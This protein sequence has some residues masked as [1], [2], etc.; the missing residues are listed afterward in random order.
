VGSFERGIIQSLARSDKWSLGGAGP[1]LFAP[2]FPAALSRPGFWDPAQYYRH[3]IGP[4]FTLDLLDLAGDPIELSVMKRRWNPAYVITEYQSPGGLKLSERKVVLPSGALVS[5]VRFECDR[6]LDVVLAAWTVQPDEGWAYVMS[7]CVAIP[8]RLSAPAGA[9]D[10]VWLALTMGPGVPQP[11]IVPSES[12]MQVPNWRHCALWE[13]R[14]TTD[15]APAQGGGFWHAGL[16]LGLSVSARGPVIANVAMSLAAAP[17]L[18]AAEAARCVRADAHAI[19]ESLGAW[20]DHFA[21]VPRF[22]CS[23][24]HIRSYYWYRWSALRLQTQAPGEGWLGRPVVCEGSGY[25]RR[26]ISYSLPAH[27]REMRWMCSPDAALHELTAFFDAQEPGGR[28]PGI[29]DI[30]GPR[31]EAFYHADWGGAVLDLLAVHPDPAF[32]SRAHHCLSRYAAWLTHE[33]DPD[34]SGLYTVENHYETG[35]EY[36]RRYLAVDPE[37]DR[38]HWGRRFDLK[39]VDATVYAYTLYIALERLAA[40]LGFDA[41]AEKWRD[42]AARIRNAVTTALWDPDAAMFF[43]VDPATGRRTGVAALTCF[44]PFL[45]DIPDASHRKALWQLFDPAKFWSRSPFPSLSMED[46]LFDAEGRWKGRRM[47]CPWNGRTWPMSNSHIVDAIARQAWQMPE[48]LPRAAAAFTKTLHV[49]FHAGDAQRPN[50]FEH[51]NPL[52]GRPSLYRGIDDYLHSWTVDLIMKHAVGLQP[53]MDGNLIVAPLP[54]GHEFVRIQGARISGC[55]V[56]IELDAGRV[57]RLRVDGEPVEVAGI[58]AMVP[59]GVH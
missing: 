52:N 29:V 9:S 42:V 2:S 37:A 23:D 27:V 35:Q 10:T 59:L 57:A 32:S 47:N 40:S 8:R 55:L 43:D 48:L 7:G 50:A 33:R 56:D 3:A 5:E 12:G 54:L 41:E 30:E 17:A 51:Y 18:A 21:G 46:P 34:G 31:P 19:D 28:F 39:G 22:D 14:T 16:R 1:V 15:H 25:F 38:E 58:P 20:E 49:L 53:A 6:S 13:T 26:A 4:L 11:T 24:E 44:Y 45:T 36:S